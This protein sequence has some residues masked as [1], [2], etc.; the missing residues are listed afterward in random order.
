MALV[1]GNLGVSGSNTW[2]AGKPASYEIE[3]IVNSGKTIGETID[4]NNTATALLKVYGNPPVNIALNKP[5]TASSIETT[6]LEGQN[7]VDG[8]LN[9][10]WSSQ[11]SDPQYL[12]IDLQS[13]QTFNEIH[14]I[15]EAAYAKEYEVQISNDNSNWTTLKHVTNGSGGTEGISA[16]ATA[17]YVRLY[18]MQRATQYGYSLYEIQIFNNEN[19]SSTQKVQNKIP[20]EFLLSNN[21]PNPFNP[22]TTIHYE[23]PAYSLVSIKVYDDLGKEVKTLVNQYQSKG[24]YDISFN[25]GSLA[26]GVY[27][28]QLKSGNFII[29][30]KMML[31]K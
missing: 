31:L 17:R 3:A 10:R 13:E 24:S 30:K 5:V 11:F 19:T 22:T 21:Y 28:Y 29:T 8:N 27:F 12:T 6:G 15:W 25:A 26:S 2:V 18:C 16:D 1:C 23:I 20:D 7:A 9:T 14:L 4:T